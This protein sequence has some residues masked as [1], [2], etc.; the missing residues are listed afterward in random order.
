[1]LAGSTISK[2]IV[3]IGGIF[4]ANYYGPESY[5]VYNVFL[6]YILI[7]PVLAGLRLDNI[8][9]LQRG[10]KEIRNLFSGIIYISLILTFILI[11]LIAIL[12]LLNIYSF[13]I[14]YGLLG[15]VG[16]ASVLTGWNLTQNNLF[17]KYKLF[18]QI[19]TA[20][21]ISSIV[22]V[23]FQGIFYLLG[24]E[25]NG[26]IYG[27]IIG[28]IA[29]FFYN[30]RVSKNQISSV[31]IQELK[32]SIKEHQNIVKFTYPSD[33][34]N[35]I[36]NNIMPIIVIAYFATS[37]IGLYG[38]AH[39]I[40]SIPLLLLTSSISRVYFQKSVSL[41][42]SDKKSLQKLTYKV[43]LTNV[44]VILVF[45][46]L[47][48]TIGMYILNRI[49]SDSW[50]GLGTYVLALSFWIL[51]RSA[52]NPIASLV[53]VI[54]KNHFSLIFNLYLLAVNLFAIYVGVMKND[55]LYCVWIFSIL[56]GIGYLVLLGLVLYYLRKDVKV[57]TNEV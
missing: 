50:A 14:S 29:S 26:L 16:I 46:I 34:I 52:M 13:D 51:A 15:L 31:N 2:I 25:E 3:T 5:G 22:S 17:T 19:S 20:F 6:S 18:K 48:N 57:S 28:L 35:A 27:W 38:M 11:S 9:I 47:M 43:I 10:S 7:L 39:K 44:A 23:V 55:F 21:I 37:E 42:H 8:M 40:L 33:S 30:L 41:Y 54:N 36:A 49:F 32:A 1:M 53:M 12:K 4:L 24:Y 45:V 56:S